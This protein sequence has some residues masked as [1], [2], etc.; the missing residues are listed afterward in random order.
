MP[1]PRSTGVHGYSDVSSIFSQCRISVYVWCLCVVWCYGRYAAMARISD[2]D[3][4]VSKAM[5]R[6]G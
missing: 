6:Y 2:P 5:V 4:G 3:L 1:P